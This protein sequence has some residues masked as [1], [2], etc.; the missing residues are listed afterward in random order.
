MKLLYCGSYRALLV[1]VSLQKSMIL[2][3]NMEIQN[4]ELQVKI[5]ISATYSIIFEVV[6]DDLYFEM[7]LCAN[8]AERSEI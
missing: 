5:K 1:S 6:T 3:K 8:I 7:Y 2:R 4:L